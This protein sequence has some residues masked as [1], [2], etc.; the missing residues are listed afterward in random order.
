MVEDGIKVAILLPSLY[1]R[2]LSR[3]S[4]FPLSKKGTCPHS[5]DLLWPE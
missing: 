4:G 2:P 3:D 5:R 1:P